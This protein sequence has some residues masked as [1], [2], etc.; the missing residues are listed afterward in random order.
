MTENDDAKKARQV[1]TQ[2]MIVTQIRLI[3]ALLM[4]GGVAIFFNLWGA[5]GYMGVAAK[6]PV[7]H[8]MGG[9]F[10]VLGLF[11]YFFVPG[12]LKRAR[13]K[14]NKNNKKQ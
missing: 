9:G 11:E 6:I 1:R 2:Q 7:Q 3:S 12:F 4:L 14:A 5:A 10:F 13:E 8:F